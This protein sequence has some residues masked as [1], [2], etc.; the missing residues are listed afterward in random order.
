MLLDYLLPTPCLLCKVSGAVLCKKCL[1]ELCFV[2]NEVNL[3]G[4]HGYAFG[5]YADANKV[6]VNAIKEQG[7]TAAIRPVAK[8]IQAQFP[9]ELQ[10]TVLV[11]VPSSPANYRKRGFQH[12]AL[13]TKALAG[14]GRG[15]SS[16]EILKS[17]KDRVDQAGLSASERLGNMQDAFRVVSGQSPISVWL[18]D[19]VLTTG[20]T[21]ASAKA[22]L[23]A[24]GIEVRGFCVLARVLPRDSG[25]LG[26]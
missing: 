14:F 22:A 23:L 8:L 1:A 6:L 3:D 4:L 13:M 7:I 18:Y 26:L 19:D 5:E 16:R 9:E 11:P 10:N 25:D 20:A 2:A 15:I 12:T 24:A 17:T 21:L